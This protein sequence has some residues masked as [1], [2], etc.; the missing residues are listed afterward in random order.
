MVIQYRAAQFA[1]RQAWSPEICRVASTIAL[2]RVRGARNVAPADAPGRW[3]VPKGSKTPKSSQSE[4]RQQRLAAE[5]RANLGK[6]KAQARARTVPGE[7]P[8][9]HSADKSDKT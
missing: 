9:R 6:R 5:L 1:V 3:I 7:S 8:G 2:C 4:R